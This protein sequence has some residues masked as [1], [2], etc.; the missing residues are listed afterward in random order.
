MVFKSCA[1]IPTIY[2]G[3][4]SLLILEIKKWYNIDVD[5]LRVSTSN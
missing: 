3:N 4:V 1:R 5:Y 2:C